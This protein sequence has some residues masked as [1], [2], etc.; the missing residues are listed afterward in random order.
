MRQALAS[1]AEPSGEDAKF[2]AM[3]ATEAARLARYAR[4]LT[5][6]DADADDLLQ[7]TML[8]CWKARGSFQAGSNFGA[9]TRTVMRNAFL[10][11]RR[12]ARFQADLPEDALDRML[13]VAAT[14]G[15]TLDLRDVDWAMGELTPEHRDA[16]RLA[17]Q[18]LPIE[19]AAALL[20]IPP[21]TFKSRVARARMRLRS[22]TEDRATPVLAVKTAKPEPAPAK[23][24]ERRNWKGVMI[25]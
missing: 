13:S 25:G 2:G 3:L 14:Q 16:L 8:R 4:R 7:D 18:G 10:S 22:L 12:R 5:G 15:E 9:W 17:S 11:G 23:R 20:S 19:E 24:R 21:G 6:A 1:T